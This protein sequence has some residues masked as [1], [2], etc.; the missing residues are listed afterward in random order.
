MNIIELNYNWKGN[1]SSRQ[2]TDLI[3]L[4]HRGG[5]GD[6]YSIHN[7]HLQ[8][9]WSGIGYHFYIRK[10]GSIYQGRPIEKVGAHCTGH[11]NHTIGV[12][13]EGDFENEGMT[14]A[15]INSGRDLIEFIRYKYSAVLPLARHSDLYATK[16][17]G[18]HFDLD[19][20]T[21][22]SVDKTV[23]QMYCDGII[24]VENVK[25]WEM[26]LNGQKPKSEYVRTIIERYQKAL[27]SKE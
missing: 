6:A 27:R 2:K 7:L 10:D 21:A 5:N 1:L 23:N 15:Q 24:S 22:I 16:C 25:N 18:K 20:I 26:F 9:G 8:N 19:A 3:V 11:N 4:H 13:F 12:C 17:P 14:N